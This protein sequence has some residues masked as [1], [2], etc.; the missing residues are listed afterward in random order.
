MIP[1]A[2]AEWVSWS[3]NQPSAIRCIHEPVCEIA[4][5]AKKSR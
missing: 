1:T 2:N 3:T 5:P 4:W